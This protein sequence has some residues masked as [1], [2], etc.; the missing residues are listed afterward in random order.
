MTNRPQ[1]VTLVS[2]AVVRCRP[3]PPYTLDLVVAQIPEPDYPYVDVSGKRATETRPALV[4][5][6]EWIDYQKRQRAYQRDLTHAVQEHQL[7]FGIVSWKMPDEDE[8]HN[9]P[10]DGWEVPGYLRARY[11]IETSDEPFERGL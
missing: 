8:F 3:I 11:K 7:Q 4:D 2:G 10:P 1:E 9:M 5:S 6:P